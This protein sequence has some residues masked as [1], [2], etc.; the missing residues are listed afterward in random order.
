LVPST[1]GI[2]PKKRELLK[3]PKGSTIEAEMETFLNWYN[4]LKST[5]VLIKCAFTH[6]YIQIIQP[7]EDGNTRI[8]SMLC[9]RL[10]VNQKNDHPN[11][12]SVNEF[13]L[14]DRIKY[15]ELLENIREGSGDITNWLIW[16]FDRMSRCFESAEQ[17]IND[18]STNI[19]DLVE[20]DFELN[21]RQITV[22]NEMLN[23]QSRT[24]NATIWC[25]K[26]Q[27][28]F[29]IALNDIQDLINKQ[30]LQKQGAGKAAKY[31]LQDTISN[32]KHTAF[33]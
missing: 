2:S 16:F 32:K 27:V 12:F 22:L 31:S 7:Y 1:Q 10:L 9:D 13:L 15:F 17:K 5:D 26:T 23:G 11:V 30:I 19:T 24:I 33:A 18:L 29:D 8:A 4:D 20:G 25:K 14:E 21:P 6:L 28:T 3:G